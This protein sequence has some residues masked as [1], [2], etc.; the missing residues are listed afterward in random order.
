VAA[1]KGQRSASETTSRIFEALRLRFCGRYG[2]ALVEEFEPPGVHRRFDALAVGLWASRG[3][4]LI[5]IEVKATEEDLRREL[6]NQ[7]K[8][9]GLY[10]RCDLW[11]LAVPAELEVQALGSMVPESWGLLV[12]RGEKTLREVRKPRRHEALVD[13]YLVANLLRRHEDAEGTARRARE[14]ARYAEGYKLGKE[15]AA[16]DVAA[17]RAEAQELR[18]DR[19]RFEQAS[20]IAFSSWEQDVGEKLGAAVAALR[21]RKAAGAV[22]ALRITEGRLVEVLEAVRIA[23]DAIEKVTVEEVTARQERE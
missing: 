11:Y 15:Q 20:G 18:R 19:Q 1:T 22:G 9:D 4:L 12:L 21:G 13:R 10:R 2:Y 3:C 16:R 5:G 6:S 17:A 23:K 7:A 8:A 14:E